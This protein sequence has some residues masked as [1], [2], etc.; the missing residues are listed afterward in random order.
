MLPKAG[1]RFYIYTII[2]SP[3]C[4]SIIEDSCEKF[5][6]CTEKSYPGPPPELSPDNFA[7]LI[8]HPFCEVV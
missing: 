7:H 8:Y 2:F 1:L 3:R 6:E 4:K 5:A